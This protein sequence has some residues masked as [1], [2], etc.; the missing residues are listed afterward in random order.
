MKH[1]SNEERLKI[2]QER[3]S[4]INDKRHHTEINKSAEEKIQQESIKGN[5]EQINSN[6]S[7]ESIKQTKS[8]SFGK[9][10]IT[11]IGI[12]LVAFFIYPQIL[13]ISEPTN[14]EIN[15]NEI[16]DEVV[17]EKIEYNLNITGNIAVI[18]NSNDENIAKAMINALQ[19]KGFKCNYFY[20]PENSNS[21]EKIY[22][23]YIGPYD[24]PNEMKQWINNIETEVEIINL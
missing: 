6:M 5:T 20:L 24:N 1:T 8:S 9:Y 21:K 16:N 2:L 23:I 10:V 17:D 3:L 7:N 12:S 19:V 22:K 15:N 13:L 4:Q 14:E 11:I 18:D